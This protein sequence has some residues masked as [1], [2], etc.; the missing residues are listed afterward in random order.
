MN[1]NTAMNGRRPVRILE[2]VNYPGSGVGRMARALAEDGAE[3]VTV[4]AHR[5]V[6]LPDAPDDFDAIIVLGGAQSALDDADFPYFP[7]LLDLMRGFADQRKQVL[8]ICLGCQ[9]VA[10]A[11]GGGNVL[12][13]GLEFAYHPVRPTAAAAADPLLN[14]MQDAVTL[15][16]WHTDTVTAPPGAVHLAE[17]DQTANQALRIGDT[18][19]AIQF[20]FEVDRAMAEA[21]CAKGFD[22]LDGKFENWR[23][24]VADQIERFEPAATAFCDTLTRRWLELVRETRQ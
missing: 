6:G 11:F 5:G 7:K 18:V 12:D 15:F 9:L 21:W 1:T 17:S 24:D 8:G 16:H 22:Y 14:V 4:D 10:R 2:I 3:R 20:H 13:T 19:Y 23:A